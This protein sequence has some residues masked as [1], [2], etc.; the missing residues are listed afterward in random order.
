VVFNTE[1]SL[2][3]RDVGKAV[4]I[5]AQQNLELAESDFEAA[6]QRMSLRLATEPQLLLA[7]ET[8]AKSRFN[9]ANLEFMIHDAQARM[10]VAYRRC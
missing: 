2:Y 1:I 8:V 3:A 7:K 5:A 9:A 10:A 4:V 6:R